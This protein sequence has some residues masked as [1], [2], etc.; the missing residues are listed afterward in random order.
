MKMIPL[1]A[2]HTIWKN[3]IPDIGNK[4]LINLCTPMVSKN[5]STKNNTIPDSIPTGNNFFICWG[6][7]K[8]KTAI[9][10]ITAKITLRYLAI[11]MIQILLHRNVN[12]KKQITNLYNIYS[13]YF[14]I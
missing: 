8:T 10:I 11:S 2:P 14:I 1:P 6:F 3:G 13:I 5:S 4:G 9:Q 7:T 12:L